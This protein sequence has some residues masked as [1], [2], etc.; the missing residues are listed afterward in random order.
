MLFVNQAAVS[1]TLVALP[2]ASALW[3]L[4]GPLHAAQ[5]DID[6]R[7]RHTRDVP[8]DGKENDDEETNQTPRNRRRGPGR[9]RPRQLGQRRSRDRLLFRFV[10]SLLNAR[11]SGGCGEQRGQSVPQGYQV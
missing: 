2:G 7:G 9:A 8:D 4:L 5:R 11:S 1:A 6:H 10:V 3:R